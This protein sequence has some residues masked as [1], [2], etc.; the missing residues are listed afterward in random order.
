M[1]TDIP[2]KKKGSLPYDPESVV[3]RKTHAGPKVLAESNSTVWRR[4]KDDPT[5]PKAIKLGDNSEGYLRS[6]LMAWLE[7]RK[8]RA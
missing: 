7:S 8:R 2:R 1:S 4:S 5:F 3:V 6:D